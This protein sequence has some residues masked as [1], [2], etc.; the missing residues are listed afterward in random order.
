ME[1]QPKSVNR[2]I[3]QRAYVVGSRGSGNIISSKQGEQMNAGLNA[4][5]LPAPIQ[6]LDRMVYKKMKLP[7]R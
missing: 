1:A 2:V 3:Q 6:H 4:N 5:L 7:V